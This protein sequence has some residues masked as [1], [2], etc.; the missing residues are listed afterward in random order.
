V[1]A[2]T[3]RRQRFCPQRTCLAVPAVFITSIIGTASAESSF[4]GHHCVVPRGQSLRKRGRFGC[5]EPR[6]DDAV[7]IHVK[8]SRN[9]LDVRSNCP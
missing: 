4:M 5:S 3:K 6:S 8:P 7:W 1:S 9:S 2:V